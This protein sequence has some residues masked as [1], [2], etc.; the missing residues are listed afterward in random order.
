MKSFSFKRTVAL[1]AMTA[2]LTAAAASP[3]YAETPSSALVFQYKGNSGPLA[4]STAQCERIQMGDTAVGSIAFSR[5]TSGMALNVH[6]GTD[7]LAIQDYFRAPFKTRSIQL[8]TAVYPVNPVDCYNREWNPGSEM[9]VGTDSTDFFDAGSGDDIIYG[10]GGADRLTGGYGSD[11]YVF[12][13]AFG[14][15]SVYDATNCIYRYGDANRIV[16]G[17]L[18]SG[19][20]T[21]TKSDNSLVIKSTARPSDYVT[22]SG[23]FSGTPIQEVQFTNETIGANALADKCAPQAVLK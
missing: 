14:A 7:T 12:N 21:F 17:D 15:D 4:L 16:F 23:F 10:G 19:D 9:I 1:W 22:I 2:L 5:S 6:V 8:G 13:G 11:T 18:K 20:V 3:C